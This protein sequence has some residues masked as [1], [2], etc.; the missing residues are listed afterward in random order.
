METIHI[1][2]CFTLTDGLQEVFDIR[3]DAQELLLA[4]MAREPLPPW[5]RLDFH[6]CPIC[7]LDADSHPHCPPSAHLASMVSR[8][9]RV[10]SHDE[11]EV[12]VVS[13]ERTVS[14]QTTAQRG[15]SSLMGL[16]M[17]SSGC[18][19]S[20]FF[21]PMA[22]FHLP[23]AS[24]DE[25]IYRATS[26]YFLAQYFLKKE[27]RA[28]DE[29]LEGLA[30][31]YSNMHVVNMSV[32]DRLR[33]ASE[34]DSSVNAIILLDMFAKAMPYV[35]EDSLEEIRYLFKPFFKTGKG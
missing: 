14:Q 22:R 10:L 26:M 11:V 13:N 32:A 23:L 17:A 2:Y 21:K 4:D 15:I 7:P 27:G 3:L 28:A 6:K 30:E 18:P 29:E 9:G 31:I 16:I 19:H 35:I 24:E 25:T 33:V 1:Q 5:T 12:V 34:T 8:F 20:A